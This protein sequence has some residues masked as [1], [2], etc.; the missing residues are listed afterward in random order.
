MDRIYADHNATTPVLPEVLE[1]MLP[2]LGAGFGNPSSTHEPGRRARA[3]VEAARASVA[4]LIGA[5]PSEILFTSCATESIVTALRSALS[6]GGPRRIVT[7]AVEHRSTLDTA[8]ALAAEG[9]AVTLLPVDGGG[10]LDLEALDAAL[11]DGA[12]VLSLL[13]ANNETGV[14]FPVREA[15]RR[16]RA[17]GVLCHCDAVQTPGR[18]PVSV[19]DL[20]VD[21]L[22]LSGHKLNAPKGVGALYVRRGSPFAPLLPGGEL[23][24]GRRGGTANVASMAGFGVAADLAAARLPR[25]PAVRELRDRLEAAILKACPGARVNGEEPRLP[26]TLN[27]SFPRIEGEAVVLSLS[28]AG[29]DCSSG[30]A[31]TS[32]REGPSHVLAAM[33]V[34]FEHLH[35]S[36]RLSL[37]HLNRPGDAD[38][39][40]AALC[41]VVRRLLGLAGSVGS[42]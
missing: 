10:R 38:A 35:G 6:G 20:G 31:C 1:A 14:I 22:S 7:T 3:A 41:P 18:I 9:V 5:R 37:S 29:I 39:I 34:P 42:A 21:Y 23:E 11:R 13:L 26:N 32:G 40:V 2:F 33:D 4:T 24:R 16:A 28:N 15:A 17:A 25:M 8:S 27:V 19:E 12:A 30:S 36:V